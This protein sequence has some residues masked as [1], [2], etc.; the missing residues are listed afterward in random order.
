MTHPMKAKVPEDEV[1]DLFALA[2]MPGQFR[3]P[4]CDFQL[5]KQTMCA[6]SGQIGISQADRETEDCPNDGTRMVPVTYKEQLSAYADRLFQELDAKDALAKQISALT[7]QNERFRAR[8]NT[9]EIEEFDKAIP[10]ESAHQVQ[11]WGAEH[12]AGKSPANWFWLVGYLAGKAL[13]SHIAGNTDK[14]KHH[15]ISTTAVLRNWHA[16]IRSGE[17]LMRPGISEEARAALTPEKPATE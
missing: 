4:Q 7:Q 11:R 13:A 15:C 6:S 17:S 16:H 9:P 1:P 10:L 8:L 3:C 14:A 5:S 2:F 12:D